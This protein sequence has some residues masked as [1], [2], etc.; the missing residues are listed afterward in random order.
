MV[1]ASR[2]PVGGKAASGTAGTRAR[3]TDGGGRYR[4]IARPFHIAAA[5]FEAANGIATG[6]IVAARR[7]VAYE[8]ASCPATC[9]SNSLAGFIAGTAVRRITLLTAFHHRIAANRGRDGLAIGVARSRVGRFAIFTRIYYAIST[10]WLCDR[11][12]LRVTSQ[13]TWWFALF[14]CFNRTVTA[15]RN[16]DLTV[17]VTNAAGRRITAFTEFYDGVSA[18]RGAAKVIYTVTG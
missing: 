18:D 9:N 10:V 8:T 4:T 2:A 11:L 14:I 13:R 6:L 1:I 16:D 5:R 15:D 12:A 3:Y 17:V 7:S